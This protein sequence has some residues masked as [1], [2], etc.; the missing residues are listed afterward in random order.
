MSPSLACPPD[1]HVVSGAHG[2][3]M[4]KAKKALVMAG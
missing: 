3:I 1:E 4:P 2:D